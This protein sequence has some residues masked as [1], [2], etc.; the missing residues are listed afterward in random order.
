MFCAAGLGAAWLK[1]FEHHKTKNDSEAEDGGGM[2][3]SCGF[4][5]ARE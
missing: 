1:A 5:M 2:S 4:R 3:R